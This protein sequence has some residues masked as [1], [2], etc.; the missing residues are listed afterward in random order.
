MYD[1]A[2]A[3]NTSYNQKIIEYL[4]RKYDVKAKVEFSPTYNKRLTKDE[5]KALEDYYSFLSSLKNPLDITL[6]KGKAVTRGTFYTHDLSYRGDKV[7][8]YVYYN[9]IQTKDGNE[10]ADNPL[11]EVGIGGQGN[12]EEK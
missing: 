3:D 6:G 7:T 5:T 1:N 10:L 9:A 4:Q 8:V 2:D 11:I 12:H